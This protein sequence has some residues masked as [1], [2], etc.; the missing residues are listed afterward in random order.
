MF[1]RKKIGTTEAKINKQQHLKHDE[2]TKQ[3]GHG[4]HCKGL[5]SSSKY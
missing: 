5:L 2:L 1:S 3:K 4:K